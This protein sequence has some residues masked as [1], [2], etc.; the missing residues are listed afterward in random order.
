MTDALFSLAQATQPTQPGQGPA[1]SGWEVF[2]RQML[3]IFLLV[4]VLWWWMSR[5][6]RKERQSFE[7]LL[8]SLKRNDRVQTVGGMLGTV[9]EVRGQE[10]VLKV[11]EANNVKIRFNR[12]AI[13]EVIREAPAE[14]A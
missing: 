5:S 12:S 4:A 1:P 9:V 13:K 11:D 6:R 3:P 10:V 8:N 7:N 2:L 14:G